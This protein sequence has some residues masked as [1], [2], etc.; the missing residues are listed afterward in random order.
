MGNLIYFVSTN[1][2]WDFPDSDDFLGRTT[3]DLSE[4]CKIAFAR[5][6]EADKEA[7]EAKE[8]EENENGGNHKN[9]KSGKSSRRAEESYR[10]FE[11]DDALL[12][13]AAARKQKRRRARMLGMLSRKKKKKKGEAEAS[14]GCSL[15]QE[16]SHGGHKT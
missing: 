4:H 7:K 12:K 2:D 11:E 3:I 8:K 14:S 10:Y 1:Q 13:A 16:L 9:K 5:K 6:L 15:S